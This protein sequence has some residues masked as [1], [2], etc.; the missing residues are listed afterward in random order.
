M[1]K[2]LFFA[3]FLSLLAS[4]ISLAEEQKQDQPSQEKQE[5]K[6]FVKQICSNDSLETE[7]N[8]WISQNIDFEIESISYAR[9]NRKDCAIVLYEK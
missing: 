7:I 2:V 6:Y 3:L 5:Q 4:P 1:P 8:S 9:I